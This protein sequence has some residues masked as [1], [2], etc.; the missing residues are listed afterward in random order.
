MFKIMPTGG[1]SLNNLKEYLSCPVVCACG[2]S[3]M[4]TPDLIDNQRWDE[5]RSLC[6][7]S[8]AIVNAVRND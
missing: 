1:I 2:G 8:V 6:Q 4:V 7:Q 3:Y 5:I